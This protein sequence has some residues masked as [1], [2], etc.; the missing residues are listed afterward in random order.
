MNTFLKILTMLIAAAGIIFIVIKFIEADKRKSDDKKHIAL[1]KGKLTGPIRKKS[2][3]QDFDEIGDFRDGDDEDG[4]YFGISSPVPYDDD[5]KYADIFGDD[6]DDDFT[7]EPLSDIVEEAE[8][9]LDELL[10]TPD[11]DEGDISEDSLAQLLDS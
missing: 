2:V 10:D 11:D 8:E 4:D 7:A 5:S 1:F 9:L 6:S 3:D